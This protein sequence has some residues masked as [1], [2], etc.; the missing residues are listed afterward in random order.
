MATKDVKLRVS[1]TG[2]EQAAQGM[3]KLD[4]SIKSVTSA[5]LKYAG[6]YFGARGILDAA[7]SSLAAFG[8]QELAEKKL[9]TA[10]GKTSQALLN[11]A[12]ALQKVSIFGDEVIIGQQSFLAALGFSEQKIKEIIPVALDLASATGIT[13]E[14]AVRNISKTYG[15]LTGELGELVPQLKDLTVEQLKNGDALQ[16]LSSL[17]TGQ[18]AAAAETYTGAIQQMKNAVGDT[19]EILGAGLAPAIAAIA[20]KIKEAQ[21]IIQSAIDNIFRLDLQETFRNYVNSFGLGMETILKIAKAT[22]DF[23]PDFAKMAFN[24]IVSDT[25]GILSSAFNWIAEQTKIIWEPIVISFQIASET[26]K[27]LFAVM[28]VNIQNTFTLITNSIKSGFNSAINFVK[29]QINKLS[30]TWLGEKLN[31][32]PLEISDII[33]LGDQKTTDEIKAQFQTTIDGLKEKLKGTKIAEIL[34]SEDDIETTSDYLNALNTIYTDYVSQIIVMKDE[35]STA[36]DKQA[37]SFT[38]NTEIISDAI[39]KRIA[40]FENWSTTTGAQ[41]QSVI[42]AYSGMTSALGSFFSAKKSHEL[43]DL[44]NS[45]KYIAADAEQ[46]A[47]MEEKINQEYG[48]KA[49]KLYRLE[50]VASLANIAMSTASGIMKAIAMS[51]ATL[52]QPWV[53]LIA[54]L[55]GIQAGI[56]AATPPPA[57]A[58]GGIVPGSSYSG[59]RVQANVNSGEMILNEQQQKK[60]FEVANGRGGG[61]ITINVNGNLVASEDEA[62][63]FAELIVKRSQ[64]GF[65]RVAVQ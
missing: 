44:R 37:E 61:G 58:T 27:M 54:G 8:A 56:V 36:D 41:I 25:P 30:D 51:P 18:A 19:S 11:Q 13:L 32:Q 47:S 9:A 15:G 43:A 7:K 31:F 10:L 57:Y 1:Q 59:D 16:M 42:G 21:P 62:D 60:L 24:K 52:G 33:N 55:G 40:D 3:G 65:N 29:E 20:G 53:S 64:L 6:A 63:R 17:F 12:S 45:Q 22:F 35:V 39:Q 38:A 46:R 4:K 23:I 50:Q 2:A 26:I 14:S 28:G 49:Q 48:K 34:I 5:A